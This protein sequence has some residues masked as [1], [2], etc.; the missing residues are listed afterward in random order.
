MGHPKWQNGT[1]QMAK[2]NIPNGEMGYPKWQNGTF[3]MVK[4]DTPKGEMGHPKWRNGIP[5]MAKWDTPKGEMGHNKS[6]FGASGVWITRWSNK[7]K[8]KNGRADSRLIF[9]FLC[10]CK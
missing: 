6:R 7:G 3:Q 5:Q 2:W 9:S 1:S 8:L 10:F 4:W